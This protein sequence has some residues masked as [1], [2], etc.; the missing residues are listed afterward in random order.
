MVPGLRQ[1]APTRLAQAAGQRWVSAFTS[2]A[3]GKQGATHDSDVVSVQQYGV[4]VCLPP[5]LGRELA[6]GVHE[7]VGG[8]RHTGLSAAKHAQTVAA[9]YS[10]TSSSTML[11]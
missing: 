3:P 8:V 11:T 1:S 7:G 4:Q 9:H 2:E 10:V 6:A 5:P